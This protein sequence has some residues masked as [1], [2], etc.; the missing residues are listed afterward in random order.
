MFIDKNEVKKHNT[1]TQKYSPAKFIF[2]LFI[3][4]TKD[5]QIRSDDQKQKSNLLMLR[6]GNKKRRIKQEQKP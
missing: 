3:G 6:K 2:S 5:Q 4:I 1:R